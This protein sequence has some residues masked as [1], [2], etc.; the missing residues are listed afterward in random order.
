MFTLQI[1]Y[2]VRDYGAWKKVFDSDPAGRAASGARSIRVFRDTDDQ[3]S[4][5]VLLD[6][7]TK[8]AATVFLERLRSQ[9]WDKPDVVG[10]LMS[11]SPTARILEQVAREGQAAG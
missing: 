4:V 2:P 6:F 1:S 11:A 7:D 10:Q 8:E 9:V 5:A 3:N